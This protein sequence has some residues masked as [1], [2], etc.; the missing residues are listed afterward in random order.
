MDDQLPEQDSTVLF[1]TKELEIDKSSADSAQSVVY[2][3]RETTLH[4][5]VVL[6]QY[7]RR[8]FKNMLREIKIFSLLENYKKTQNDQSSLLKVVQTSQRSLGDETEEQRVGR[9]FRLKVENT[10]LHSYRSRV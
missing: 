10:V 5:R 6:K 8:S 1:Y 3:G 7:M 9:R 2:F 4:I